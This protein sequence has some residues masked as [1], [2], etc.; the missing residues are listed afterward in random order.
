L[1][2]KNKVFPAKQEKRTK[3]PNE[4][5]QSYTPCLD[6]RSA[7]RNNFLVEKKLKKALL[8]FTKS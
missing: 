1:T 7:K 5:L 2:P 8:S 3:K 6:S 4:L